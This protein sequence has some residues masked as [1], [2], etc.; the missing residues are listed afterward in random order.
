[1]GREE[2]AHLELPLGL[3]ILVVAVVV[4]TPQVMQPSY[5]GIAVVYTLCRYGVLAGIYAEKY[6][7]VYLLPLVRGNLLGYDGVHDRLGIWL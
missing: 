2:L 1:M 7:L 6:L 4:A 3:S 5:A